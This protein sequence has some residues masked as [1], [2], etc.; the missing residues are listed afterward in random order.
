MLNIFDAHVKD[1]ISK[2]PQVFLNERR[3]IAKFV[4]SGNAQQ[5]CPAKVSTKSAFTSCKIL[6]QARFARA[7]RKSV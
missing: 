2:K 1:K 3:K 7:P 5:E 6:Q 4:S